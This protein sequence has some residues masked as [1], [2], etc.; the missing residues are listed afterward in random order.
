MNRLPSFEFL[1]NLLQNDNCSDEGSE[2]EVEDRLSVISSV[3]DE[4]FVEELN[5]DNDIQIYVSK[6]GKYRWSSQEPQQRGRR[7]LENVVRHIE[8][9]APHV[10]PVT[11]VNSLS[12]FMSDDILDEIV[13]C[14]NYEGERVLQQDWTPLCND[15]IKCFIG[16]L[17]LIGVLRGG[18]QCIRDYWDS[19]FGQNAIIAAMSR[20]RFQ[21]L[22]RFLRFDIRAD[23]KINER[24]AP[25]QKV[26]DMFLRNC[27]RCIIPATFIC[28][29]EQIIATRGRCPFRVYMKNKPNR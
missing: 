15:E 8:G 10:K 2:S 1:Q 12:Y 3:D 20:N 26:W 6:D 18:Y 23:R 5:C 28:I 25:I 21:Q 19:T 24:L 29:D 27:R 9:P 7:S 16:I 22:L 13:R 11:C 4:I 14:T 17:Y